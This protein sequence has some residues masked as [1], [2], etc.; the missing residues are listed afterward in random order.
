MAPFNFWSLPEASALDT[1][2]IVFFRGDMFEPTRR[3]EFSAILDITSNLM[4]LKNLKY[5]RN[6]WD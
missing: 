1:F 3:D 5:E 2:P 4:Q 6:H